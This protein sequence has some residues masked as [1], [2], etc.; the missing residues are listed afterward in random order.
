MKSFLREMEE[1]FVEL[2]NHCE[3][4]DKPADECECTDE[5]DEQ[6]VTGAIAGYNTPAAF[7]KT[8]KRVGYASGVEESVNRQVSKTYKPGHYQVVEFDEE[9]QNDKFSF[10]MDDAI[11]WNKDMEYPS[12]DKT[13]TPGTSHKKDH[14]SK[15]RKTKL[16]VEDVLERKYEQLIEG[17][18]TFAT[19]DS[20]TS[21][22][23]KVKNTIKEVAKKLHEIETMVNYNSRL[24][25]ESGV[26]SST[27]GNST[28]KAL[29]KI[30]ER[31][32]KISERVR[33]LGE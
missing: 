9:V 15:T 12:K 18:R 3:V 10:A 16:Q 31:L 32:V 28:K 1:K 29:A 8:V 2:E 33:A 24:K 25:T 4:C 11:W 26:T 13:S 21:P 23:Q 27:Y 17:Y 6:N 20:K 5:V 14:D 22:E 19:A 30:S 7:R